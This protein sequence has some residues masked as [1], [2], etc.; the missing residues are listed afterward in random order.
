MSR[1]QDAATDIGNCPL[2]QGDL[3]SELPLVGRPWNDIRTELLAKK[4]NDY[5]WRRGRIS[6][7]VYH[8]DDDLLSV[9]REAYALYFSENA[10]GGRA[11]P[12]LVS[13][14]RDVL[15]MSLAL[16]NAP[17]GAEGSFTSGGTESIFL[18]LKTARDYFRSKH[19]TEVRPRV[20]A[21]RT[22]HPAFDKAAHYLDVEMLRVGVDV[23]LRADVSAIADAVD[24]RTMMIVGSAPCYPYGVYDPIEALGQL[25]VE[26]NL[27]LHVDACLGGFLAPFARE[28][29]FA[30]PEFDFRITGVASLS[31]DLHKYGFSAKGASVLL[32]RSRERKTHQGFEFQNWPR[33][34][35]ATE[36]F[37]GTRAGGT[38]ASAWAVTQ[39]LGRAGYRRLAR[40]TMETKQRL[41]EGVERLPGL[42]AVRPS[43]LCILLYRSV[44]ERVDI[45]AVAD[46][47][48]E[49][50]WFVGRSREPQAIHF[51]VNAVHAP[52][53]DEYVRDLSGAV[54]QA[55]MTGRI[56]RAD[57]RTY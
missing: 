7:Y 46:L 55:R 1:L 32:Y 25:A 45:N 21:A 29:G 49:Q 30:V 22:A 26:K 57:D 54:R 41:I 39:F 43:E 17:S 3:G 33:G 2:P 38:I 19:G 11:F 15:G 24:A 56:G 40:K 9:A 16:F 35:Y 47:M 20:I 36:T 44:D 23:E 14:E 50:G 18:A 34:T 51:A 12:S 4:R 53:V 31:A 37:Q 10:L 8:D 28:E 6:L 48:A 13:M 42:E 27:W 5:D 52:I